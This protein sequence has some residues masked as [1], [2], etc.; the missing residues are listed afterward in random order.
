LEDFDLIASVLMVGV[1][2]E[3]GKHCPLASI[4]EKPTGASLLC[5][6]DVGHPFFLQASRCV[7]GCCICSL[8]RSEMRELKNE[9]VLP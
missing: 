2:F 7:T 6:G 4:D 8:E 1:S 5:S 3:H 9:F